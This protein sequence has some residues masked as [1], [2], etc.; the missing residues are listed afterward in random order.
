MTMRTSFMGVA[1]VTLLLS[2]PLEVLADHHEASSKKASTAIAEGTK[3]VASAPALPLYKPP[4]PP[5]APGFVPPMRGSPAGRVG[6]GG[7]GVAD[8]SI[9]I[10]AA[11]VPDHVART[12]SEQPSLFWYIDMAPEPGTRLILALRDEDSTKPIL[13]IILKLEKPGVQR[14]PLSA[15]G[16]KLEPGIEYEWS[17]ALVLDPER[18]SSDIIASGWLSRLSE[19][20]A[21]FERRIQAAEAQERVTVYAEAGLWYDALAAISDLIDQNPDDASLRAIR[22]ALLRQVGF[23]DVAKAEI[24]GWTRSHLEVDPL[25][26]HLRQR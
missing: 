1:V 17:V 26:P 10:V 7:R 8:G 25:G 9:P 12:L 15:Y 5:K 2:G 13:E 3:D 24:L 20:P 11:L 6:A 22:A 21:G 18:R 14:I 19:A 4:I 16:V 23:Q